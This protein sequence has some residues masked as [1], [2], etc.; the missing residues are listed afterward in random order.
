MRISG[1]LHDSTRWMIRVLTLAVAAGVLCGGLVNALPARAAPLCPSGNQVSF[2]WHYSANGS[3]GSW[4][5]T[6]AQACPSSFSMGPQAMEGNLVVNPGATVSAGYDFTVPGNN[7]QQT[8]I[9]MNPNVT[10]QV[11]CPSGQPPTESTF[12]VP[13]PT[14][15]YSFDDASWYPS[16]SQSDPSTYQGSAPMPDLCA[17]GPVG[18]QQG[19][20]F[21]ASF[22]EAATSSATVLCHGQENI[23]YNPGLTYTPATVQYSGTDTFTSCTSTPPT[24]I[25]SASITFG[26][27][28]TLSCT[29]FVP[30]DTVTEIVNWSNGQTSTWTFTTQVITS[31][32]GE[33]IIVASG[34]IVAGEFEG[35]QAR[36][37]ISD[38]T[39]NPIA[40]ATPGGVTSE[41]GPTV[42]EVG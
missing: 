16:G 37:T 32:D 26:G 7:S 13:M 33:L 39:P 4:S 9:V 8:L 18:L 1:H 17:G 15:T 41:S 25:T 5:A 27:T 23:T 35:A 24:G 11:T 22:T 2:R 36:Q 28:A 38:L 21:S 14:Q 6:A 20:T 34:P 40:C 42:F 3:A 19:G 12:V 31:P 10:F 29:A 30:S